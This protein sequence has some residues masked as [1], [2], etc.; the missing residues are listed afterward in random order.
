MGRLLVQLQVPKSI[1]DGPGARAFYEKLTAP[2]PEWEGEIRDFVIAK[3]LPRRK[4][5]QP[6]TLVKDGDVVLKQHPLTKEGLI[7]SCIERQI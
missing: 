1:A 5:V 2:P 6:L 4:F 3:R 7:A